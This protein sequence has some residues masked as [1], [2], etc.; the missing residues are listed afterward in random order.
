M[1]ATAMA[2]IATVTPTISRYRTACDGPVAFIGSTSHAGPRE[3]SLED[4]LPERTRDELDGERRGGV[5]GV[6][7]R[8]DLGDLDRAQLPRR[9][10]HLHRE[11]R[12]AVGEAAAHRR[13]D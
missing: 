13:T 7:D 10:E 9:R 3:R 2:V 6:E 12:L 4:R 5:A 1:S 8:I 11:L